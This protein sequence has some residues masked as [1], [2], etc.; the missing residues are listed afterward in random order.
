MTILSASVKPTAMT[1]DAH[2]P[3]LA[4]RSLVIGLTAFL[5]VVDLFATQ[6]ILPSLTRHYDVTPA[7]MGFAVNASTF[8]MATASLVV[9]FFSPH[10]D[11]RTGILLSL[12]LLAI[13]TSLLAVAPNLAVFT[14]LRVAQGLCMA[15]AFALTLTYLG[16]QCSAMDAGGAFAAYIT[17]NVASNFVGRLISAALAD[18]LGLAWNFYFFAALNLAGAALVY[19]TVNRVRPMH[20]MM[21][22]ASPL[23][24]TIEHWRN[25]QLRAAFGIGF[26]ILFAFIGTFTYVNFV[27]VRPPLSLGMMDLGLVYFVFLPSIVTTLLAG[28]VAA[29]LGTRPTIWS[30]LAV[31]GLG[32][33][34][35]LAPH[36]GEVLAGMV[37]VGVGTFFAQA[38]AT[39]FV[40]QAAAD[41]RG[42]ASGAY[43]ACYFCGGLVGTAV[44]GRLFDSFGWQACIWGVGAV[45]ALA[46]L[47]TFALKR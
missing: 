39:G 36:L 22:A 1:A 10:I 47:L 3:G 38:A 2:S 15:S 16:E 13:P 37:L 23:A 43:L 26:C 18:G 5:T 40:G 14:T 11:R 34:L 17:G 29:R 35:M 25:P 8:G 44:L 32:L 12:A 6:A 24:A 4:F 46:A 21:P 20:A 30:A 7:A 41:N 27:L 19:L 31:A 42:I 45:L 28:K 9:G 33:P